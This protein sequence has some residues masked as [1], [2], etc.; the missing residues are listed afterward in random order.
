MAIERTDT[1]AAAPPDAGGHLGSY[2]TPADVE[3]IRDA[4]G[5]PEAPALH[6]DPSAH[7]ESASRGVGAAPWMAFAIIVL[8]LGAVFVYLYAW[9]L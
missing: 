5:P 7:T 2:T 3:E 1:P 9:P 4:D 8:A 6:R